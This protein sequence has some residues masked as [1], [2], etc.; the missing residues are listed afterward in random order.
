MLDPTGDPLLHARLARLPKI[1]LHRHL[2]GSL[3]LRSLV[4]IVRATGLDLP[5]DEDALRPLVQFVPGDERTHRSFLAKFDVLRRFYQTPEIIHRLAYEAAADAARDGLRYLELRFTPAA[6][7]NSRGFPLEA[8]SDWV[9]DAMARA[10]ADFPGLEIRLIAGVNRHE[11]VEVAERV[12]RIAA[13]RQARGLVGLDLAGDEVGYPCEPF[14]AV[15]R[16]AAQAGLGLVAH[17]GEWAG[18][19][20]VR[21]AL[22]QMGVQRIG[23]GVRVVDDPTVAALARE[24]GVAFEVCLTSNVQTGVAPT[25]AEHPW[26]A[27]RA[28]DLRLTLNSDDPGISAI[29]LTDEYAAL[30]ETLGRPE[31]ELH[32]ALLTAAAASLLPPEGQ[33]ALVAEF[34]A[35]LR[36]AAG[37]H[38]AA[39]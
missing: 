16:E 15:F 2:E 39:P 30:L 31:A 10:C 8:V 32:D 9:L 6:L 24:R 12:A 26:R 20:S 1:D 38:A 11:P 37:D 35:V 7:A 19:D 27:M 28:L 5:A 25:L 29:T 18:A 34:Q 13:D 3:R 4:E 36:S 22:E 23:H 21:A 14:A 33:A 17:A